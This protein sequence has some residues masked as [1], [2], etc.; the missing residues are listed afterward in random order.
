MICRLV[1]EPEGHLR[2]CFLLTDSMSWCLLGGPQQTP[3]GPGPRHS[4]SAATFQS[5][6]FVFG[7]LKGLQEQRDLWKWNNSALMWTCVST[8]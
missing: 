6:M 1:C 7:G 2:S 5:S 4:H 8:K 3:Q